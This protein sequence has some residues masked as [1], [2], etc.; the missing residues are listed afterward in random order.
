MPVKSSK[1]SVQKKKSSAVT[2][3]VKAV[4]PQEEKE[5]EFT[6]GGKIFTAVGGTAIVLGMVYFFKYAIEQGLLSE[7][8]RLIIG[9]MVGFLALGLGEFFR[10]GHKFYANLLTA[11]GLLVLYITAYSSF[12][13]YNLVDWIYAAVATTMVAILGIALSVRENS[14]PLAFFTH[15]G[16]LLVPAFFEPLSDH[17]Q[18]MFAYITL[19][20]GVMLWILSKKEW[21]SLAW[22]T[23]L[24]SQVTIYGSVGSLANVWLAL[25]YA[26]IF[27]MSI[28]GAVFIREKIQKKPSDGLDEAM[29]FVNGLASAGGISAVLNLAE[30]GYPSLG[31]LAISAVYLL[32][33]YAS[34]SFKI[35]FLNTGVLLAVLGAFAQWGGG[36]ELMLSLLVIAAL[37]NI[38]L[39]KAKI[40][41][42]ALKVLNA[43]ILVL[44]LFWI[45]ENPVSQE[46]TLWS[47]PLWIALATA[48]TGF[49]SAHVWMQKGKA[50]VFEWWGGYVAHVLSHV[51]LLATFLGEW[52]LAVSSMG[53]ESSSQASIEE[54]GTSGILALYALILLAFGIGYK[55]KAYRIA[56]MVTM[57]VTIFKVF[58]IDTQV[59]ETLYKFIA[60]FVL[61]VILL[62]VGYYY[63]HNEKKIKNFI[64][65][66]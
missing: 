49:L 30:F 26:A 33:A 48:L 56:F 51:V 27:F 16:A 37:N 19:L 7:T 28:L 11:C 65:G 1:K 17:P 60:F 55:S 38:I 3:P 46:V 14:H 45:G 62:L 54:F 13:F 39:Y 42:T 35:A 66:A 12:N 8:I 21:N 5:L 9:A 10:K 44:A 15:M 6:I 25:P 23:L 59:L 24:I 32:L 22:I 31:F 64:K 36:E 18:V 53:L 2:K 58:L 61:G 50:N 29:I 4:K 43:L 47:Y 34:G 63:T 41:L 52:T 57:S 40:G 20:N